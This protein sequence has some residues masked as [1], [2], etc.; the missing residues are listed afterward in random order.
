MSKKTTDRGKKA[1]DW[2]KKT[3]DWSGFEKFKDD[4]I[5]ELA[6]HYGADIKISDARMR[7]FFSGNANRREDFQYAYDNA[8]DYFE[9]EIVA[10][11]SEDGIPKPGRDGT[12]ALIAKSF[13]QDHI[14]ITG[15]PD[16]RFL[17]E[18]C[19]A[20]AWSLGLDEC[21]AAGFY[22]WR[23]SIEEMDSPTALERGMCTLEKVSGA[24]A[25]GWIKKAQ[26]KVKKAK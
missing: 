12:W 16:M 15:S 23:G 4:L 2:N 17:H 19:G 8:C 26:P 1:I 24:V 5:G 22:L 20:S 13:M 7:R 10:A 18:E 21:A 3:I 25:D 11:I 9:K 14:L 6:H